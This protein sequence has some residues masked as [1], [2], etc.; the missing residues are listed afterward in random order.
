MLKVQFLDIFYYWYYI[1]F[2]YDCGGDCR[3]FYF[4]DVGKNVDLCEYGY[5]GDV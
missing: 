5:Y 1:Y 4:Y 3:Y 2:D